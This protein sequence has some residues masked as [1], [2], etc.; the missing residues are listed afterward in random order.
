MQRLSVLLV[1]PR[2]FCAGVERAIQTVEEALAQFGSPVF[3]RHEIVHNPYVVDKLAAKGAI[4]V[5][6]LDAVPDAAPSSF[7]PMEL[8]NPFGRKPN[9]AD[10]STSMRPVLWSPRSAAKCKDMR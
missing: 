4:F 1:R 7:R 8:P 9:A 10:C 5:E 6:E 2:G 3:V